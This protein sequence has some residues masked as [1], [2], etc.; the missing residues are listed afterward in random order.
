M[1]KLADDIRAGLSFQGIEVASEGTDSLQL[2]TPG[3]MYDLGS[4]IN[5][6][7]EYN[8]AAVVDASVDSNG[9]FELVVTLPVS[10]STKKTDQAQKHAHPVLLWLLALLVVLM[11]L[12]IITLLKRQTPAVNKA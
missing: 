12:V 3:S 2:K 9:N 7:E 10:T 6:I 4:I 1:Q 8:P 5:Q 11:T